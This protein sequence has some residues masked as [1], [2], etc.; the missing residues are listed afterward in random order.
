MKKPRRSGAT[1]TIGI[2]V[3]PVTKRNLKELAAR[4]HRGNVS[5]LV[6][7]MT[8]AAVRH[9]AFERAWAW[10]AGAELTDNSR[11]NIDTEF[12]EGWEFARK[13]AKKRRRPDS[14]A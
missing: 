5:S 13:H 1:E 8:E 4:K 7:E 12:E 11:R 6:A 14:A 2:S 3:D 9:A 10:Y